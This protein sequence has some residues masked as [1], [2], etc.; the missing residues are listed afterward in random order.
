MKVTYRGSSDAEADSVLVTGI[1]RGEPIFVLRARDAR[2]ID[3]IRAY[4]DTVL[5]LFSPERAAQLEH[6]VSAW[7][8][9]QAEHPTRDPD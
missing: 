2:T 1:L 5:P 3:V 6:D 7:E 4:R 9:W 8:T